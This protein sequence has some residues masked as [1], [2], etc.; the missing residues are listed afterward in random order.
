[1]EEERV[2][3]RTAA[4]VF[5]EIKQTQDVVSHRTASLAACEEGPG[6]TEDRQVGVRWDVG[7][8]RT[9]A[10]RD[11]LEEL[12]HLGLPP[13]RDRIGKRGNGGVEVFGGEL[14]VAFLF[15][16]IGECRSCQELLV[17]RRERVL[18]KL[19]GLLVLLDQNDGDLSTAC[20]KP[21]AFV[22]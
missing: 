1:M 13:V 9:A 16:D 21:D 4:T 6:Q 2:C 14:C 12:G 11:D 22:L 18:A 19:G 10:S 20:H 15:N 17:G 7:S 8:G 5:P 3:R